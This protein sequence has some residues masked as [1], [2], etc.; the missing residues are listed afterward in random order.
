MMVNYRYV[1]GDIEKAHEGYTS[2][3]KVAV[4]SPIR[5]LAYV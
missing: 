3:K 2:G 5:P 4:G 1:L